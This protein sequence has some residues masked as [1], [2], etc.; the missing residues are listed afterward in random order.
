[1]DV[2]GEIGWTRGYCH[3]DRVRGCCTLLLSKPQSD[4]CPNTFLP[5]QFLPLSVL[6]RAESESDKLC[7]CIIHITRAS[8]VPSAVLHSFECVQ[9][10]WEVVL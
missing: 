5:V 4:C 8:R 9:A 1:M 10:F 6:S 3:P 2:C 7:Y